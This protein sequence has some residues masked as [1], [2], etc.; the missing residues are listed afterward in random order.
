MQLLISTPETSD[1]KGDLFYKI[2]TP[3]FVDPLDAEAQYIIGER[4]LPVTFTADNP[5][6]GSSMTGGIIVSP[7]LR[8]TVFDFNRYVIEELKKDTPIP[9]VVLKGR[10]G[11]H[12][13]L[14]IKNDA[15]KTDKF[16]VT[17][18]IT[19]DKYLS[20]FL[21]LIHG[22]DSW[23]HIIERNGV[24]PGTTAQEPPERDDDDDDDDE[25][26]TDDEEEEDW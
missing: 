12:F 26:W 21:K 22:W 2:V 18:I 11:E 10:I 16:I 14:S 19:F 3:D 15:V 20:T 24:S 5:D 23:E 7:S 25:D 13:A 8:Q 9:P 1:I 17:D 6:R 4:D